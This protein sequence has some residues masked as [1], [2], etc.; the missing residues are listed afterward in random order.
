MN[1]YCPIVSKC[2]CISL[3]YEKHLVI[4]SNINGTEMFASVMNKE[5]RLI[6]MFTS[7]I[8]NEVEHPFLC[9]SAFAMCSFVNSLLM[10]LQCSVSCETVLLVFSN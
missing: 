7:W 8:T 1:K 2:G 9:V 10:Y 4:T 6:L 5:W 3:D